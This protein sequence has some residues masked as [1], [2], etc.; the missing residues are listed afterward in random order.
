MAVDVSEYIGSLKRAVQPPGTD[1]YPGVTDDEWA[2]YLTDAFWEARL[3]GFLGDWTVYAGN[4]PSD[5]EIRPVA[6]G[7]ADITEREM[8]LVILYAS[9]TILRGRI[10]N[11]GASFRGKAGPVEFEQQSSATVLAEML[12]QLRA[13]KDRIV[14][15]LDDSEQ[16]AVVLIDAYSTR[17]YS[18]LS[19]FGGM[20]LMG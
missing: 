20:E 1:L 10:L 15:A 12:K 7:G 5:S 2:G 13:T 16:T 4:S 18:E 17:L 8:A 19:Y 6:T 3:D 11:L 9:L 14:D